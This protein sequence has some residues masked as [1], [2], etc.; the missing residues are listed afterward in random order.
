MK[1]ILRLCA[2]LLLSAVSSA[3]VPV[4]AMAQ[5]GGPFSIVTVEPKG[6][7]EATAPVPTS[8]VKIKVGGKNA[9]VAGW[10]P[11][12]GRGSQ[13]D[14]QLVLLIDDSARS[15]LG[16]HLKE[17]QTFLTQ[18]PPTTEEA[19]IYM[20]N[21]S[22]AFTAPFSTDHQQIAQTLRIPLG[23]PGTGGS[24]NFALSDL[25]KR[26]PEHRA[27]ERREVVMITDGVDRYT[28]L[29]YD[30]SNPYITASIRDCIRNHVVVYSI[31][32]RDAGFADQTEAG[33][34][35]GQNYLSQ[36]AQAVGGE[37]FYQGFTNPVD[38]TPYLNQIN[39][40]LGNQ[41]E[42]RVTPPAGEKGIVQLKV[43]VAAPNTRTQAPQQIDLTP[44]E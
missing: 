20:R 28:G 29:R 40:K 31:Y 8:A 27:G 13:P 22:A 39:R 24:A 14:L 5:E 19:V 30:P 15:S 43:Q 33:V 37:F 21:G 16:L 11:Y 23:A 7:A 26:W 1:Q 36:L 25:I 38:F 35:S 41:Y 17:L 2:A 18:Q 32:Y 12:G 9:E 44:A 34:N 4:S 42:L 6:A 10:L 3:L